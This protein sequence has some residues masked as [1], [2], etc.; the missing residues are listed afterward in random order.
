[1]ATCSTCEASNPEGARFCGRCGGPLSQ[2]CPGAP[3][4]CR[5]QRFCSECGTAI[6]ETP[7]TH[8]DAAT[9]VAE[10]ERK[11]VTVLCCDIVGSTALA[12]RVGAEAMHDLLNRFFEMALV[13]VHRYG[14]T[15]NKFLGDGFLA[16]VGVPSAHEDHARRAVLAALA[17]QRRLRDEWSEREGFPWPVRARVGLNSGMVVVGRLGDDLQADYTAIG[18][19]TNVAARLEALAEPG[20]IL[21]S[22][23]TA[24]QVAGYVALEPLGPLEVRGKHEPVIAHRVTGIGPRRSPLDRSAG[25]LGRF[26]GRER[27]LAALAEALAEARAGQGQV[28]GVVGDPGMGKTRLVAEFRR[29]LA[30]E[31]ITWLE[32]RCLSYGGSIPFLPL[33]DIVRANC[34]IA[35]VN[36]PEAIADKVRFSLREVGL[37]PDQRAFLL[38]HMLG[39]REGAEAV[40]DRTPEAIKAATFETLLQLSLAGSRQRPIVLMVEDLHWIDRIS[41]EWLTAL[42]ENLPGAPILLLA[43]HRPGYVAP[44]LGR[45]DAG[46]LTLP[47]LVPDDA[48]VVV[49]SVLGTETLPSGVAE[50]VVRRGEGNPFFLEELARAI[51]ERDDVEGEAPVPS[52]IQD[53][54]AARVDRLAEG[55]RRVLQTAAVLGREFPLQLL[56][57]VWDGPG[58][59]IA[60]LLELKRL[61][62]L[63][64]RSGD[65]PVY[66]FKHALTQDVAYA[67][68]LTSRRN[69]LHEAA[70]GA[71]E[72]LYADRL[73]QVYDRLAHHFSRTD[74]H[75]KAIEYLTRFAERAVRSYAHAEA[76]EALREAISH[77][78][79]LPVGESRDRMT[80]DLVMRLT[81]SMYFVSPFTTSLD[82]LLGQQRVVERLGDP[83]V[84]GD[85]FFWLGHTYTHAGDHEGAERSSRRAIEEAERAGD[86]G[87][88]GRAWYVLARE[89][90]WLSR[91]AAGADAGHRA[92]AALRRTDDWWWLGHAHCWESRNEYCRGDFGAA[93]S[94][95]EPALTIAEEHGDP[96]LQS[97]TAWM[98]GLLH[99]ERGDADAGV[100]WCTRSLE[101]SP[102]PLNSAYSMGYL[103]FAYRERGDWAQAIS[104][105]EQSIAVLAEFRYMRVVGWY[106][107]WLSLAFLGHGDLEKA[108]ARAREGLRV[109]REAR[110][111]RAV[112]I[113][114]HALGVVALA[115]G[116]LDDAERHLRAALVEFEATGAVFDAGRVR[117][118]LAEMSLRRGSWKGALDHA[119]LSRAGFSREWTPRYIERADLLERAAVKGQA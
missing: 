5:V 37:D 115:A 105:L 1:M 84:A 94:A 9:E 33:I 73:E 71:L 26:V 119:R 25:T 72:V 14:G 55:P 61:E 116:E 52:T 77:T 15:I 108:R 39:T 79:R 21:I 45:S 81:Y 63:F 112:A 106:E 97:Y 78:E 65:E 17:V 59:L 111:P 20:T 57:A 16:L 98:A 44:W 22:D 100:E 74:R 88:V 92:V 50:A 102:D 54:L 41:E 117:L 24:R 34:G 46:Q 7:R 93:F 76:A 70:G 68:L 114:E 110:L 13:E 28:V 113:A 75:E 82:L 4:P 3:R 58:R 51:R 32:G 49:E 109:C 2:E 40:A 53:V 36:R 87:T 27:Q 80:M 107:A 62:F 6:A 35:D 60:H 91:Y 30:G 43:T 47:R 38:L 99:A 18:D 10:G 95:F 64:E 96:R 83:K 67:T 19:T 11:Q 12:E 8:A 23:S 31:R 66:V 101:L 103:G 69:A 86:L 89:G 56:E 29:S 118:T 85:Y 42:V 48:L 90:F 104:M